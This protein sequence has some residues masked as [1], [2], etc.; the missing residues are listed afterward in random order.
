MAQSMLLDSSEKDILGSL[1]VGEA[2]VKLQ[3]RAPKPFLITIPEFF[4]NKGTVTDNAVRLRMAHMLFATQEKPATGETHG[5]SSMIPT[6]TTQ[7][8]PPRDTASPPS[9]TPSFPASNPAA[10][11]KDVVDHPESGVAAR[12]KR[13]GISVR[14]GQKLKGQLLLDGQIEEH[15]ERTHIGRVKTVRLTEEGRRTLKN[16]DQGP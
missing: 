3:G 12:Y 4:I 10:F 9:V 1:E 5:G 16:A 14:Q 6:A 8:P 15:E 11:L 13:L 7:D 2:V